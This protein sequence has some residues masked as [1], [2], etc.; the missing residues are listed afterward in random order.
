MKKL[1]LLLSILVITLSISSCSKDDDSGTTPQQ[2]QQSINRGY[3]TNNVW[4]LDT[5]TVISAV[6]SMPVPGVPAITGTL[7]IKTDGTYIMTGTIINFIQ[8]TGT[9]QF[10]G[11]SATEAI[12]NAG[13]VDE[14]FIFLDVINE[15]DLQFSFTNTIPFVGVVYIDTDWEPIP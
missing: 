8:P 5:F 6:D 11:S 14:I 15:D 1:T 12:L 9:W 13:T 7:D 10:N 4:A 3:V 2:S